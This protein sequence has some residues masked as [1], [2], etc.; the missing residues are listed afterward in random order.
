MLINGVLMALAHMG[1]GPS[2]PVT[3]TDQDDEWSLFS[4]DD[5][6]IS[7][8]KPYVYLRVRKLFDPPSNST[9]I[10]AMDQQM[11]EYEWRMYSICNYEA[12]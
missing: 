12:E 2:E 7:A 10:Q 1:V 11:K 4:E 9:I 5:R 3:V 6:L 8:V